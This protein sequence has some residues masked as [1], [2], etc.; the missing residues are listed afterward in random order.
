VRGTHTTRLRLAG[1]AVMSAA[2]SGLIWW[3]L[4][5][6]AVYSPWWT[7][8]F[9][10][11]AALLVRVDQVQRWLGAGRLDNRLWLRLTIAGVLFAATIATTGVSFLFPVFAALVASVHLQWSGARAWRP[12]AVMTLALSATLQGAVQAGWLPSHLPR[13]LDLV[14]AVITLVLS[15]LLIGNVAVIAAQREA[16]T[17]ALDLERRRHPRRPDRTPEP[18]RAA[19]ALHP[20]R[21]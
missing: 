9:G 19:G 6:E 11:P 1:A 7:Q 20:L 8:V 13:S 18:R 2:L 4:P 14:A 17:A 15:L 5:D 10:W 21:G 12:C 3:A 16:E